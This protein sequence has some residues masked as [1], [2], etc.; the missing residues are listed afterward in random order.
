MTEV[1]RAQAA[2]PR[3]TAHDITAKALSYQAY[4][5][6]AAVSPAPA[7]GPVSMHVNY[8]LIRARSFNEFLSE[9]ALNS[10]P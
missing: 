10:G 4:I 3:M 9:T 5:Y 7:I 8:G 1:W 6:R 2:N